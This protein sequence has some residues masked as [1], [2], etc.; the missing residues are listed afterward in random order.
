MRFM[1][2]AI[3]SYFMSSFVFAGTISS[4]GQLTPTYRA[5]CY[6]Q[7]VSTELAPYEVFIEFANA[8]NINLVR[9]DNI[10]NSVPTTV[11]RLKVRQ[12]YTQA[13]GANENY[14]GKDFNLNMRTDQRIPGGGGIPGTFSGQI[15][16]K[17][18]SGNLQ[19]SLY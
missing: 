18:V 13:Q 7:V 6:L 5:V 8:R 12:I 1:L 19:C 10:L 17:S 14:F 9:I 2:L 15:E 3:A 4:G 11:R 16:G